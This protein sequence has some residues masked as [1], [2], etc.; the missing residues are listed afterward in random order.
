[1]RVHH[2]WLCR[3]YLRIL[4]KTARPRIA[5]SRKIP[6]YP[7]SRDAAEAYRFL[8]ERDVLA[9]AGTFYAY[10]PF[11]ALG[12]P[13]DSGMRVGLAPYTDDSVLHRD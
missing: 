7:K 13:V 1:M 4:T 12:L 2:R 10:E 9:P 8:G 5:P 6:R 3:K 11:R